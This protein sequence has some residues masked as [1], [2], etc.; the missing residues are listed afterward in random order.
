MCI[1]TW[2]FISPVIHIYLLKFHKY[3]QNILYFEIPKG[4]QI[5]SMCLKKGLVLG[6]GNLQ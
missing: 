1:N 2:N 6:E 4:Y 3:K 5:N